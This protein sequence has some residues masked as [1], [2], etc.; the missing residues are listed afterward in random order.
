MTAKLKIIS[1]ATV[2]LEELAAAFVAAFSGYFYPMPLTAEQLSRRVRFEHLD[3]SRSLLAYDADRLVGMAMLGL[4]RDVAWVGGFGITPEY[5]GRGRAQELMTALIEEARRCQ[6]R[7]LTLEVLRQNSAAIHLYE[8][9]GMT[10]ARDLIIYER[11]ADVAPTHSTAQLMEAP[12]VEL[13]Q[14]F[15]RLHGQPP[16]WQRELSALLVMEDVRGL[17]LG[18]RELPSAY[19]LF[20][21]GPNEK[22]YIV[23]LAAREQADADALCAGLTAHVGL[24]SLRIINE[25]ESSIFCAALTAHGF[26]ESERQHEMRMAL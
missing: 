1:A 25:P 21:E 15:H 26:V 23:D 6:A 10:T 11:G 5:R 24:R 3:I 7:T 2:T 17:Y 4:R 8:R 19:A 22:T 16:A 12:P 20:R 18:E 13:L 14:H 9:A